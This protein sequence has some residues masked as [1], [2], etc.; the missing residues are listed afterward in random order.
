M[1]G[2]AVRREEVVVPMSEAVRELRRERGWTQ[3]ALAERA[4]IEQSYLSKLENG[5]AKPS[6]E[7]CERLAAALDVPLERLLAD[8]AAPSA[9][10]SV[11]AAAAAPGPIPAAAPETRRRAA[12]SWW[13]ASACVLVAALAL[14]SVL[15]WREAPSRPAP[16]ASVAPQP[17]AIPMAEPATAALVTALHA[18][19]PPGVRVRSVTAIGEGGLLVQ[20]AASSQQAF[21]TFLVALGELA[22]VVAYELEDE[23]LFSLDGRDYRVTLLPRGV[24]VAAV[25]QAAQAR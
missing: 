21:E 2:P 14:A 7:V 15:M 13:L 11:A 22:P 16:L 18:A 23:A 24:G 1:A 3:P 10:Q 8:A 12:R 19:A 5:R 4:R 20:G 17:A 25:L 6:R 9:A